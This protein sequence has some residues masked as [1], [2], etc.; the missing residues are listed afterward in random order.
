MATR[1]DVNNRELNKRRFADAYGHIMNGTKAAKGAQFLNK[2]VIFDLTPPEEPL[3]YEGLASKVEH[4]NMT[5]T[6]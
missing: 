1:F 5:E 3:Q 2:A 4:S 6:V